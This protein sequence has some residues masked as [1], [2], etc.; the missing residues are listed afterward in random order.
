M[1]AHVDLYRKLG[2]HR[3]RVDALKYLLS[4][5]TTACHT[6]QNKHKNSHTDCQTVTLCNIPVIVVKDRLV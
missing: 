1:H 2:F 3:E 4:L 5:H 6:S